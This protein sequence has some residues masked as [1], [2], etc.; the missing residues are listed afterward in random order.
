MKQDN[1]LSML[2]LARKAG[3]VVSGE[4]STEN[5]I[6]EGSARLVIVSTDA[7]DNTK[8]RFTNKCT[9]YH[10]PYY[11]YGTKESLGACIGLQIRTSVAVLDEGLASSIEK[12]LPHGTEEQ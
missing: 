2:G 11:E 10:V 12:K 9:Y 8:K 3:K 6:R 1:V 5:A 7:S 4:F